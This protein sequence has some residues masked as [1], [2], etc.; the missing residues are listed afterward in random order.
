MIIYDF[1][2]DTLV[3]N[4]FNIVNTLTLLNT[5]ILHLIHFLQN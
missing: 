3:L 2:I 1:F 4:N 5:K